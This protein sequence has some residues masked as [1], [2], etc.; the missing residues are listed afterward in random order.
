MTRPL[1]VS[2]L[3]LLAAGAFPGCRKPAA[4]A[5]AQ[6]KSAA[7]AAPVPVKVAAA[8]EKPMPRFLQ[9]T[10]E[11]TSAQ[12]SA[13]AADT[14]GKVSGTP[15]ERGSEVKAGEVLIRLDDR[16]TSLNLAEAEANLL[17]AKS[18]L[19]LAAGDL[20]RNE[21][22]AKSKAIPEMEY[23][24]L[25]ADHDGQAATVA[26]AEARRDTAR[27]SQ[28]DTAVLAPFAG[29]VAERLVAVGEY[30]KPDTQVVRLVD[31]TNLRLVVNVAEPDIG[32]VKVGQPVDFT[33][34]AYAGSIFKGT[35]KFIGAA[36]RQ[37]SRDLL[38]EV[39][40]PNAD[41]R[42]RP[43]LFA[44]ARL[45]LPDQPGVTVPE[46]AVREDGVQ[47]RLWVVADG[48]LNE[49]LVETGGKRDG[50]LEIR[51]GVT[52][53]EQVV[54]SPGVNVADGGRVTVQP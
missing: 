52:A 5:E 10:G 8:A 15:V 51:R 47:H 1:V 20:K 43:G 17:L 32:K 21:P 26:A 48:R 38:V 19:A 50:L 33:V 24:R 44:E 35:V 6:A 14:T 23:A 27:K 30:V 37:G 3:A 45:I 28:E 7:E 36:V 22:L 4:S 40:A 41:G 54:L 2:C 16:T 49:R 13:V 12:D 53:G 42:L 39:E 29:T 18:K 9:L 11:L 34:F 46:S 25:K 31:L